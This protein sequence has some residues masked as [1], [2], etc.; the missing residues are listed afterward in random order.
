MLR[1]C[2]R[3]PRW[4]SSA[5]CVAGSCSTLALGLMTSACLKTAA[6]S[7][8]RTLRVAS[9]SET[10]NHLVDV[11]RAGLPDLRVD[12]HKTNGSVD[13]VE[14]IQRGDA[15]VALAFADVVYLASVGRLN[16][17]QQ[18]FEHL[19][20]IAV[21][22]LTPIYVLV[23]GDSGIVDVP[24]LRGRRVGMSIPRGGVARATQL[25]LNAFGVDRSEIHSERVP[26]DELVPRLID[27]TVDAVVVVA[28][29]YPSDR[30]NA[31]IRAGARV[32]PLAGPRVT[33]LRLEYPFFRPVVIPAVV[34]G[35]KPMMTIGLDRLLICRNDLDEDI[36]YRLTKTFFEALPDLSA[37]EPALR[38]MDVEEAPAT[39]VTLHE[40]AGR[41]YREREVFR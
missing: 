17:N 18:P 37:S 14:A 32:L 25:V 41:Y 12:V 21:L 30:V 15:D 38:R 6:T 26:T 2:R 20:G 13:S 11:F 23:R 7:P 35:S 24:G 40:G 33:K 31:A 22:Q 27:G 34:E 39:P 36:V 10:N 4:R 5:L 28:G 9:L 8:P 16:P 1:L 29:D 3:L 19:R